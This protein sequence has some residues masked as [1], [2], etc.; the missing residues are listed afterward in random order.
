MRGGFGRRTGVTSCCFALVVALGHAD[1]RAEQH[2]AGGEAF[3]FADGSGTRLLALSAISRPQDPYRAVCPGGRALPVKFVK[4]TPASANDTGRA[5]AANFEHYPG[6][7]FR[8]I[9]GRTRADA[10]CLLIPEGSLG[11]RA[12]VRSTPLGNETCNPALAKEVAIQ[13]GRTVARCW[14]KML[15]APGEELALVLFEGEG[16]GALASLVLRAPQQ[17]AFMDFP[18]QDDA[19]STWRVDDGGMLRP[20]DF[21]VLFVMDDGGTREVAVSWAGAEGASLQLLRLEGTGF[22]PL[23]RG[24]RYWMPS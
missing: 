12:I 6:D 20:D 17:M 13:K 10:T 1:G 11:K 4:R 9:G 21:D 8:I 24:Y 18:G 3:S 15:L 22:R 19:N 14:R 23:L 16:K 5:T 2:D 7:L